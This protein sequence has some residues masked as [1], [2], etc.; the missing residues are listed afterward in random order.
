MYLLDSS[1]SSNASWT[2]VQLPRLNQGRNY[3]N[4]YRNEKTCWTFPFCST[5]KVQSDYFCTNLHQPWLEVFTQVVT[6]LTH[7]VLSSDK[8]LAWY[9]FKLWQDTIVNWYM[10]MTGSPYTGQQN[11]VHTSGAETTYSFPLLLGSGQISIVS[12]KKTHDL[13]R[14]CSPSLISPKSQPYCLWIYH[15]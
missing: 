9:T 10:K 11:S 4:I 6:G 7:G 2:I 12:E 15:L 14:P 13:L 1:K 5:I 3:F 8:N